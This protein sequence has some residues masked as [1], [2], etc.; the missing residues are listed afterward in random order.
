MANALDIF[1]SGCCGEVNNIGDD[2]D[3]KDSGLNI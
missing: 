3:N 2:K 1:V